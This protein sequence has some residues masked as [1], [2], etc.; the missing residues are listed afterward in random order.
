MHGHHATAA[1]ARAAG[2]VPL[3]VPRRLRLA[4]PFDLPGLLVSPLGIRAFNAL[5]YGAH[6]DARGRLVD[7]ERF[8]YPLDAIAGWNRLYGR[9]GFVQ[10]QAVLPPE[11]G[12]RG[13]VELLERLS[14]SGRPS[15]L[16]VLKRFGPA[17]AGL[18]SFPREGYTLALDLPVRAGLVPFLHELERL[19][20]AHGG[21]VY[22]AKDA[23]TTPEAFRAMY[24]R[25]EEFR[26]VKARL[27]PRGL[28][29]SS[30]ARR[31][32]IVG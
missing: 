26:A 28:L 32:G 10:Y 5:Y 16:A 11:E 17:N 13:L 7:V 29:S 15:F 18:L 12:P 2:L 9:R 23:T 24:P 27:D 19:V 21:R 20:L 8:F 22:L 14:G 31:L 4:V 6:G 1:A 25:L 30:L 3:D